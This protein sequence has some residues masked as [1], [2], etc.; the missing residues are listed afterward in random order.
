MQIQII[1]SL[2]H[3][4]STDI[5]EYTI[6]SINTDSCQLRNRNFGFIGFTRS[7]LKT[8]NKRKGKEA[9]NMM[10]KRILQIFI[11]LLAVL[12]LTTSAYAGVKK[13]HRWWRN[14][15]GSLWSAVFELQGQINNNSNKLIEMATEL[16]NKAKSADAMVGPQ[17]PKGDPGPPGPQGPPGKLPRLICGGCSFTDSSFVE[18][19]FSGAYLIWA[20]FNDS[21]LTGANFSGADLRNAIFYRSLVKGVNM[22][23]AVLT[24][25]KMMGVDWTGVNLSEVTLTDVEWTDW[26]FNGTG[27]DTYY[28]GNAICPDGTNAGDHGVYDASG[29]PVLDPYYGNPIGTCE[30][31][32]KP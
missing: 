1:F 6:K 25:A 23:D 26:Y 29:N 31:H 30:G 2:G 15:F 7:F 27:K 24:G 20:Q 10:K 18:H 13:S 14:P 4:F 9:R 5:A 12:F 11:L 16:N 3:N 17:G 22:K 19:N 32:L 28:G 8:L 21:D